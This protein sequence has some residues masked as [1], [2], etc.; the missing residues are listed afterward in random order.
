VIFGVVALDSKMLLAMPVVGFALGALVGFKAP[1][2]GGRKGRLSAS[3][4]P[5]AA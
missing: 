3:V 4:D 2:R 1:R 5:S